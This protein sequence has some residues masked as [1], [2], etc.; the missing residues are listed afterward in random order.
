[1][2]LFL[3]ENEIEK[4]KI[5]FLNNFTLGNIEIALAYLNLIAQID[6]SLYEDLLFKVFDR[7]GFQDMYFLFK[8]IISTIFAFL[9]YFADFFLNYIEK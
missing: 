5:C 3:K 8:C 7:R 4:L 2:D 1:M 9:R 6:K